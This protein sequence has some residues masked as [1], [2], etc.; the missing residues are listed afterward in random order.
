MK[1]IQTFALLLLLGADAAPSFADPA[2]LPRVTDAV[3]SAAPAGK[4]LGDIHPIASYTFDDGVGGP[5]PQ[6][7]TSFDQT[8]PGA[9]FHVTDFAGLSFGPIAGSGSL[10]CGA[11][12]GPDYSYTGYGNDWVQGFR[13]VP[14]AVTGDVTF[15]FAIRH[16]S[17]PGADI[18]RVQYRSAF[19]GWRDLAIYSGQGS[20]NE[21]FLIATDSLVSPVEFRFLFES[22]GSASDD[23]GGYLSNGGA[24]AID[25][26]EVLDQAGTVDL[27]S[28][29]SEAEGA[30]TT[31]DGDWGTDPD[32][33]FGDFAGLF[34]GSSV[35]QEDAGNLNGTW[36]WGFF[37]NSPADYGCGGFPGQPAVPYPTEFGAI[38]NVV[39]SPW[40]TAGV[41]A[42]S[43][44]L[45]PTARYRLRYEA[46]MDLE[47]L[48]NA[49]VFQSYQVRSLVA[50]SATSWRRAYY[51]YYGNWDTWVDYSFDIQDLVHP[52]ATHFQVGVVVRDLSELYGV[53]PGCHSHSP[54]IDN[55]TVDA[56]ETGIFTVTSAADSGPGSLR[57]A[58]TAAE[59]TA[60]TDT[61]QFN[62]VPPEP[63]SIVISSDLPVLTQPIVI[64]GTS[65]EGYLGTPLIE[66]VG[67]GSA[68]VGLG[69]GPES[70]VL[71]LHIRDFAT[72]I[73]LN[74]DDSRLE[75]STIVDCGIAV[76]CA[77][78][79]SDIRSNRMYDNTVGVQ[80]E[81]GGRQNTIQS[82]RIHD[83]G[84][85]IDLGGDGITPNDFQD[86][87]TGANELQNH[88][89]ITAVYPAGGRVLATLVSTPGAAFTVDF[90]RSDI[91][92]PTG[93]GEGQ[94]PIGSK[95]TVA[96][97]DGWAQ[98]YLEGAVGTL[99]H[100]T[101]TA[102]DAAGNTSEFSPCFDVPSSIVV[103]TTAD[104]GPGSL[105]AAIDAANAIAG[106]SHIGFDI[107]GSGVQTIAPLS[108]LPVIVEPLTI[109]GFSQFGAQPNSNL[110]D[111]A[112]NAVL[113]IE[114]DATNMGSGAHGLR[115]EADGSTVRGLVINR[116]PR[117]G[118]RIRAKDCV[119]EGCYL[120]TDATGLIGR[121]NNL[122]NAITSGGLRIIPPGAATDFHDIRI[123]GIFPY[124]RNVISGNQ[125]RGIHCETR[126][127]VFLGNFIGVD[128]SGATALPN[129]G[130]GLTL[131]AA[132]TDFLVGSV[133]VGGRNVISG[134]GGGGLA[135][136]AGTGFV[137]GNRIGTDVTGLLPLPNLRGV[138]VS[139]RIAN[140]LVGGDTD[141][142]ANLIAFNT[143]EG[144]RIDEE[145][146]I[147][148]VRRNSIHSN[149]GLG[150]DVG[151]TGPG[152]P[153]GWSPIPVVTG[154]DATANQ[155]QGHFTAATLT[156]YTINAYASSGCDPS[157]YGEGR[158]HLGETVVTPIFTGPVNFT[159][160]TTADI[161]GGEHVVATVTMDAGSTSEFSTCLDSFNTP[162]GS[163]VTAIPVDPATGDTPVELLFD[164]VTS[165]GNTTLQITSSAPAA[166]GFLLG[167]TFYDLGTDA[168]FDCVTICIDYDEAAL[169][170]DEADLQLLHYN[171]ATLTWEDI[172]TSLDTA[173]DRICGKTTSF[174]P[175]ALAVTDPATGVPTPVVVRTA[176]HPNQPNPF[177]PRTTIR[178]DLRRAG[179][180][181][182]RVFDLQGRRVRTLRDGVE[183]A[184]PHSV[185]W[186][187]TDD[188]GRRVATGVF[189]YRL[190]AGEFVRVRKMVLIK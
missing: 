44:P 76:S 127:T 111:Q 22:N 40:L 53:P 104:S 165:Q 122:S 176:L 68:T 6:G 155:V 15:N 142:E 38:D 147:V 17:E 63:L 156:S 185:D 146:L 31:L 46:Y 170:G 81:T 129:T 33:E 87:D 82:N 89:E 134:N 74:G 8:A 120:G 60:A 100:V 69:L 126:D 10:W 32:L 41:D 178:Y 27:Q 181:T 29:E 3:E 90:Y 71:A 143:D 108:P 114:I 36:F 35:V 43:N 167:D 39:H 105:R 110:P 135:V 124:S 9:A 188:A 123:G 12:T 48:G 144:V 56:I 52:D 153:A 67:T 97:A 4:A 140:V 54:L 77:A 79:G 106:E 131:T 34:L 117:S 119:V 182:L 145:C 116:A 148:D 16:D 141:A 51:V 92:S 175:F 157:G 93:A 168:V 99:A 109:D 133:G 172:T 83:N 86:L 132:A 95:S 121:G 125:R 190:E 7:W 1:P 58:L 14:F 128:S 166:P 61:I 80:V 187:G 96:D 159:L 136:K 30:T 169:P 115:V 13:S 186:D 101:A 19:D 66:L 11:R 183:A 137:R 158:I 26:I 152:V 64:D 65:Q 130:T 85:G 37:E 72:G 18:T 57:A 98:V 163:N 49:G 47:G 21:S 151:A 118:I 23:D 160:S 112:S 5:D 2:T 20:L 88:P 161:V 177:N 78:V 84:L 149:G 94:Y 24:V 107:P 139:N 184:G 189:L 62:L 45:P 50:G 102:T 162:A 28:F 171:D 164:N 25:S 73:R 59:A 150:I 75:R 55:V 42:S 180:V 70:V 173:N 113:L 103:T 154:V 91:C 174:S 179:P 138:D